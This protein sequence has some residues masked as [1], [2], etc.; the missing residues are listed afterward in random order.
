MVRRDGNHL[1]RSRKFKDDGS[2]PPNENTLF[3]SRTSVQLLSNSVQRNHTSLRDCAVH[4][5]R[6]PM[7]FTC[8]IFP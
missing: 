4:F 7:N 1:V 3:S 5:Y 2:I 8:R 6:L